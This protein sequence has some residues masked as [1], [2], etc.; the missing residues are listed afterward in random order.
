M[1]G[2]LQTNQTPNPVLRVS[3]VEMPQEKSVTYNTE[4]VSKCFWKAPN[5][6][7]QPPGK[8]LQ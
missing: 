2:F 4:H 7:V 8:G 3:G 6:G 5:Q 1:E